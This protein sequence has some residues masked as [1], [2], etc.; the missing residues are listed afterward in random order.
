MQPLLI[1]S[2]IRRLS[3]THTR[4]KLKQKKKQFGMSCPSPSQCRRRSNGIYSNV[5]GWKPNWAAK[6]SPPLWRF[7]PLWSTQGRLPFVQRNRKQPKWKF[8]GQKLIYFNYRYKYMHSQA[9]RIQKSQYFS[10]KRRPSLSI[11]G[12]ESI[13]G[14]KIEHRV[15]SRRN[16]P[17]FGLC[18]LFFLFSPDWQQEHDVWIFLVSTWLFEKKKKMKCKTSPPNRRSATRTHSRINRRERMRKK[19]K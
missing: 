9:V 2:A 8:W 15:R 17:V 4:T 12:S 19:I 18:N 11:V 13:N 16:L 14:A 7:V 5:R 10:I 6:F 3:H 1:C